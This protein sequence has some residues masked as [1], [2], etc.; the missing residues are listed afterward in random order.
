T[1][2][3]SSHAACRSPTPACAVRHARGYG[4]RASP[5]ASPATRICTCLPTRPGAIRILAL[6][7]APGSIF[8]IVFLVWL[9]ARRLNEHPQEA[10][11]AAKPQFA[12][13]YQARRRKT[14]FSHVKQVRGAE[15]MEYTL[16]I[17]QSADDFAART[18]PARR[19]AFWGAFVPYMQSLYA[20][21][22]VVAG[23]GLEPPDLATT[24]NVSV[25][26]LH[27]RH[28]RAPER[29][30]EHTSELQSLTNLVC[31]LLLEK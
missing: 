25:Q 16:L 18:D 15:H 20:A 7:F 1:W 28:E 21:G 6:L 30:E 27:E 29:S 8:E 19:D 23:T 10:V 24:V 12:L 2:S 9:V 11:A 13:R 22:I 4:A 3:G 5:V 31:R 26:R 17:Y 14:A